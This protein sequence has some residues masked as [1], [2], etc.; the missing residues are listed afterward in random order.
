MRTG[1]TSPREEY[2]FNI[3][4]IQEARRRKKKSNKN[5]NLPTE[6]VKSP[7]AKG[8]RNAKEPHKL[9][10]G[11]PENLQFGS[12]CKDKRRP[13]SGPRDPFAALLPFERHPEE[14]SFFED[15]QSKTPLER[16]L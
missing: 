8:D 7:T 9:A 4:C 10:R 13:P 6:N 12:T 3:M 11:S 2:G 5:K 15:Y 16:S 14:S 1:F